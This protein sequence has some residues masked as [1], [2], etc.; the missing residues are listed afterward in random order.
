MNPDTT[1]Y[2]NP[3]HMSPFPNLSNVAPNGAGL[4]SMVNMNAQRC[5]FYFVHLDEHNHPI[6]GTMFAKNNNKIVGGCSQKQARLTGETMEAPVG[7]IQCFPN[8]G[9]RYWYQVKSI[10]V[11]RGRSRSEI[12]PNSMIAVRGVPKGS[13]GRSCQ[14]VEYKIFKQS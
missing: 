12:L 11:G 2:V 14:Y 10:P 7:Y 1:T 8:N 3:S 5:I 6:P 9:L 4:P 13:A